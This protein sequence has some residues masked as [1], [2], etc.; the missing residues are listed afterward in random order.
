MNDASDKAPATAATNGDAAGSGHETLGLAGRFEDLLS[1]RRR[2]AVAAA[3]RAI[4][5]S[6]SQAY[7]LAV[8]IRN[9]WYDL[10][11][12]L[13]SLP[14]P[15]I[16][17]GNITVGGT[18]KT[19]MVIWLANCLAAIG[20]RPA[21]VCRGYK[22]SARGLADELHLV[23]LRCPRA[24]CIADPDRVRGGRRAIAEGAD[25]LLLDD[26]FQHRRLRRDLDIVLVDATRPFGYRHLLPRGL[27][28]EPVSSL[29]RAGVV[30]VTRA[31][32]AD[33]SHVDCLRRELARLAPQTPIL[34]AVHK[35]AGLVT[36]EGRPAD[37]PPG[38]REVVAFAAI[39][40][41]EAFDLT[42]RQIGVRLSGGVT[43]FP[44]HH[45]YTLRDCQRLCKLSQAREADLITTEKDAAKLAGLSVKWPR[46][47][48]AL[49]VDI[50]F[51]DEDGTILTRLIETAIGSSEETHAHRPLAAR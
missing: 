10:G 17:V 51:L 40:N 31:D 50:E 44:D 35:P 13:A 20:R 11:L 6:A 42:L 9:T 29:R 16:S 19:P 25:V 18:G 2:G 33:P 32:Q 47:I 27:L 4:L 28:R 49:R 39:G 46:P 24:I 37:L 41:P 5:W 3:T 23:R 43:R 34:R 1:G 48:R 21:V 12:G 15:V 38:S 45:A 8:S 36:L 26:G 22:R 14:V 30:V 7:R